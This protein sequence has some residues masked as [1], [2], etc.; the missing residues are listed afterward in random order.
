M[1]TNV[2]GKKRR[3]EKGATGRLESGQSLIEYSW[4]RE[5]TREEA[6]GG[7]E[8]GRTEIAR[9]QKEVEKYNRYCRK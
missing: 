2:A 6:Q 5:N 4:R 9:N 7:G 1:R 3:G 8:K